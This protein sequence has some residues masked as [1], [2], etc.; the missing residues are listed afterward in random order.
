MI[1]QLP[2][3]LEQCLLLEWISPQSVPVL[4]GVSAAVRR[5]VMMQTKTLS[6]NTHSIV[7]R[8]ADREVLPDRCIR[9]FHAKGLKLELSRWRRRSEDGRTTEYFCN[10]QRY[11]VLGPSTEMRCPVELINFCVCVV[12]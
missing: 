7:Y 5:S 3:S 12:V 10:G 6:A 4:A 9:W 1:D 8:A 2:K 11:V